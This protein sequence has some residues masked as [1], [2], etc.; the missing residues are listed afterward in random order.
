MRLKKTVLYTH[1]TIKMQNQGSK[2][3]ADLR[4][5]IEV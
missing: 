5:K 3:S 4:P 2:L 1:A